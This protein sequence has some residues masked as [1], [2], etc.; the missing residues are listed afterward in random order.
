MMYLRGPDPTVSCAPRSRAQIRRDPEDCRTVLK[1]PSVP[2]HEEVSS[3]PSLQSSIWAVTASPA[4]L[5]PQVLL[6]GWSA[7]MP[8]G[9]TCLRQQLW[10]VWPG[11]GAG[12][13]Q[14]LRLE[15][16]AQHQQWV[17][18]ELSGEPR[19]LEAL[20]GC[21]PL[22][23]DSPPLPPSPVSIPPASSTRTL[24]PAPD[25]CHRRWQMTSD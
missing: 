5:E 11:S 18:R 17:R 7:E 1:G 19:A 24:Y 13:Q 16:G 8:A 25:L 15:S 9:G 4:G 12:L 10:P 14:D 2:S 22:P 23:C 20:L 21:C 6:G 3:G